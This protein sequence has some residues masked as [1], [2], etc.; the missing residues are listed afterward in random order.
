MEFDTKTVTLGTLAI[1]ALLIAVM[2]YYN[3][4]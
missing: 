3:I 4:H 1:T 2:A